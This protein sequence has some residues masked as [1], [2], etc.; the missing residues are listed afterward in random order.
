MRIGR[1]RDFVQVCSRLCKRDDV[2]LV[3]AASQ[4]ENSRWRR[5]VGRGHW[6]GLCASSLLVGAN[7]LLGGT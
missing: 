6:V 2:A 7:V 4:M 3:S 1:L 5:G